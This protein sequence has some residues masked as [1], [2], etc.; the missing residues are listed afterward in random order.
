MLDLET[1][2]IETILSAWFPQSAFIKAAK[3][4]QYPLLAE[5]Q[6]WVANA[7]PHRRQEFATGRWLAR[8]GLAYWGLEQAPIAMGRLRNPVWP[9]T[10]LGTITHDAG[11]C[12]VVMERKGQHRDK[13]IGIDLLGLASEPGR[14]LVGAETLVSADVREL[15]AV[16]IFK[17]ELDPIIVLFSIKE[18]LVKALN[19]FLQDF[20][21]L[22]AIKIAYTHEL[23]VSV[24]GYPVTAD[25]YATATTHFLLTA[26]RIYRIET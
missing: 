18:S 22:R 10:V 13:G 24:L 7:V 15:D 14:K 9:E 8:Q 23:S 25:I 6:Q 3:I 26:A 11:V 12:A 4:E 20:I 1:G 17:I 5:E 21:D 19:F 16:K 2:E